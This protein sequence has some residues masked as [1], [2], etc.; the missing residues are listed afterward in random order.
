[1][2]LTD[3]RKIYAPLEKDL[4]SEMNYKDEP[5]SRDVDVHKIIKFSTVLRVNDK[6]TPGTVQYIARHL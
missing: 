3:A 1:M 4:D 2:M 6:H 5:Q